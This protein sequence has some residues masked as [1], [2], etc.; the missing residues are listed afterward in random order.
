MGMRSEGKEN[1]GVKGEKKIRKNAIRG[2]LK[3][4]FTKS[5]KEVVKTFMMKS[6]LLFRAKRI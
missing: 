5:D 4:C 2:N 1:D 3:R 6:F